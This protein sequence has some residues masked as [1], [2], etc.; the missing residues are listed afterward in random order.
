MEAEEI[1][2]WQ[3]AYLI[4]PRCGY[5]EIYYEAPFDGGGPDGTWIA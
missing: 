1:N 4:C 5:R 2:K 3:D